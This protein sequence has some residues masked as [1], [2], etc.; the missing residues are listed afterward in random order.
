MVDVIIAGGN[1][2]GTAAYGG[3]V[4]NYG[5]LTLL[6]STV[7]DNTAHIEGGGI[8]N[9]GALTINNSTISGNTSNGSAGGLVSVGT[10]TLRNSTISGNTASSQGAGLLAGGHATLDSVTVASNSGDSFGAGLF[11]KSSTNLTITNSILA[12]NTSIDYPTLADCAIF[13]SFGSTIVENHN[14]VEASDFCPFHDGV[15]GTMVGV[16]P[17]LGPLANNGGSTWTHALLPGSPA[18]NA[19]LTGLTVD[20]RGIHRPIG[21]ADD[22][23]SFEAF[24]WL[25]LPVIFK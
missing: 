10:L 8:F 12:D 15:N 19:G 13:G 5:D 4:L 14:L 23:G 25:W 16:D 18:I 3:G 24:L 22:I 1:L 20:Q 17:L 9:S 11:I 21:A 2:T 6:A 7:K